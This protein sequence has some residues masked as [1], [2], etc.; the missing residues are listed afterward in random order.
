MP[1]PFT[2][3]YIASK[4]LNRLKKYE[5]ELISSHENIDDYFWGSVAPDIRYLRPG[6]DR[7]F[8]HRPFSKQS[9]FRSFSEP[10]AFLVGYQCH[11]EADRV[12]SKHIKKDFGINSQTKNLIAYAIVDDYFQGKAGWIF[13]WVASGQVSRANNEG[14]VLSK[15]GFSK[16]ECN[17]WKTA[18]IFY[19]REPGL[20]TLIRAPFIPHLNFRESFVSKLT[21]S[22]T[23]VDKE[24]NRFVHKSVLLSVS[25]IKNNLK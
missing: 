13:P 18:M 16:N 20:D 3:A 22:F 6:M 4:A 12:W 15:L 14:E 8:T 11:L 24:L 23:E 21:D 2:H 5:N 7:D 1:G 9:I 19:L 25:Q 10:K 17:S